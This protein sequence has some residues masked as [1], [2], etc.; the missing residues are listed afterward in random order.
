MR[1]HARKLRT[2]RV[3]LGIFVLLLL[4]AYQPSMAQQPQTAAVDKL[5]ANLENVPL[6]DFIRFIST[7]TGR[8]IVFRTDQI[9]KIS[10]SIYSQSPM[11]ESGLMAIF[12][13]VVAAAGLTA[14]SKDDALYIVPVDQ[15]KGLP[16]EVS[17][18]RA[19]VG[20]TEQLVTFVYQLRRNLSPK[21]A[22]SAFASLLSPAGTIQPIPQAQA[23]VISDTRD[24]VS[25]VVALLRSIEGLDYRWEFE[26]YH[27]KE[28]EAEQ[29]V[30]VL[31]GM[32]NEIKKLGDAAE[33]TPL[34]A[35]VPWANAVLISGTPE[36]KAKIHGFLDTLDSVVIRD[37]GRIRVYRLKNVEATSFALVMQSLLEGKIKEKKAAGEVPAGTGEDIFKVSADKTTNSLL[38]LSSPET[39]TQI[40][41]IIAELDK[42]LEQVYVECLVL[43][44]SL[45]N[46]R[47]FGVEW[48]AGGG[49]GSNIGQLGFLRSTGESNLLNYASPALDGSRPGYEALPGGFSLG[50][51]G[52][53]VTYK[54]QTFPTLGALVSFTKSLDE[55]NIIS[56]PQI[57]TLDNAPAEVFVGE[58]RPFL[59]STKFDSNNNPVQTYEYRDVGVKLNITPHINSAEKLIRLDIYQEVKKLASSMATD[60]TQP[61][62]LT[63]YTKT[64]VQILDST[65]IV[66]SGLVQDDSTRG[67]A[68]VPGLASVPVLGWLFKREATSSDK[69]TLM[70][71]IS[72]RIINTREEAKRLSEARQQVFEADQAA[73]RKRYNEEFTLEGSDNQE[74]GPVSPTQPAAGG[75]TPR[76][77]AP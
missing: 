60:T 29:V 33:E 49:A 24:R 9:P 72:A 51:L 28:A 15:A 76:K 68:G 22:I 66:I 11:S 19:S 77:L 27:L 30:T 45:T 48:L 42:P 57:M 14:V 25:A 40:E 4:V 16:G 43:E 8:N 53:M 34:I 64:S 73:S 50:V 10:F 56:T 41:P 35:A 38:V 21:T 26:L 63:R 71:F 69:K 59:V 2:I 17:Q 6:E 5:Q 23:V 58:N 31:Q 7:Y 65:T 20:D 3:A 55:I 13:R 67:K 54:G 62:T 75:D 18:G 12:Q 36:Q 44:T 52:N 37:K 61:I 70:V 32:Y 39:F 74:G 47:D 46:A 1:R